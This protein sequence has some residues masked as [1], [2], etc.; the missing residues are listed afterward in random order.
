M[1]VV[2]SAAKL[3]ISVTLPW[4]ALSGGMHITS[5]QA[6]KS[7][8]REE[9]QKQHVNAIGYPRARTVLWRAPARHARVDHPMQSASL[10]AAQASAAPN[11]TTTDHGCALVR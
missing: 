9:V 1:S 11:G 4:T 10:D 2:K 7:D 8:S 5:R 6:S 3:I